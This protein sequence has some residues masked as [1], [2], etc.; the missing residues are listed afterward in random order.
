[1]NTDPTQQLHRSWIANAGAWTSA[2]REA[3]IAS[4][5]A[6]TDA[7][8]V[9]AVLEHRPARVLDLG[10]GEGWLARALAARGIE[11]V[12]VD[13]SEPLIAAAYEAGGGDFHALTYNQLR[14]LEP[15]QLG[16]RFGVVAFNFALLEK[17][18]DTAL[19]CA[20]RFVVQDGVVVIQTVHPWAARG[21][22]PYEDGWRTESF[23]SFGGGFS[24]PMPWFF[25][26][27]QSWVDTLRDAGFQIESMREPVHPETGDPLSLIIS[28]RPA[29]P[30][31]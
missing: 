26:T 16:G 28:S 25:R 6:G 24:E 17:D 27:L 13:A 21:S 30:G 18:L 9:D 4:R 1:M 11:V 2:V 12:G 3:A 22:L 29:V 20:R 31:S 10:C 8:I 19:G 7:A 23:S 15:E 14:D 5:R